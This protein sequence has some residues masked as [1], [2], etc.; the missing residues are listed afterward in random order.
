VRDSAA[1]SRTLLDDADT[2][3]SAVDATNLLA[4][5]G[6]W[7]Q[8]EPSALA[9][10]V[11]RITLTT[12]ETGFLGDCLRDACTVTIA[13]AVARCECM[14][15]RITDAD[16]G[17]CTVLKRLASLANSMVLLSVPKS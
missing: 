13:V 15:T 6:M 10:L 17:G 11:Q 12:F 3:S 5:G 9:R 8:I 7:N 2:E 16:L 1:K 14:L 4:D